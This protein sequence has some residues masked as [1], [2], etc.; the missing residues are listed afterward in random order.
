MALAISNSFSGSKIDNKNKG[1]GTL[2]V[3]A[4]LARHRLLDPL[5]LW[6]GRE[7]A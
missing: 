4:F 3:W 6:R 5:P 2:S 1:P 7:L